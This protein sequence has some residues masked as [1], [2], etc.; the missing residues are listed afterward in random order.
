MRWKRLKNADL[1]T[2]SVLFTKLTLNRLIVDLNVKHTTIRILD[3]STGENLGDLELSNEF[4]D[5]KPVTLNIKAK[6]DEM[7]FIIIKSFLLFK[8]HC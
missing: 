5:T 8:R 1:D 6:I 3:D 4:F 7:D 2:D